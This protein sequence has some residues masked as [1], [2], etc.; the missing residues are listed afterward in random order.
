MKDNRQFIIYH[1]PSTGD[2]LPSAVRT[3]CV[4][5]VFLAFLFWLPTSI[6]ILVPC[7]SGHI[8]AMGAHGLAFEAESS[9]L[10]SLCTTAGVERLKQNKTKQ[11]NNH[12]YDS[13]LVPRHKLCTFCDLTKVSFLKSVSAGNLLNTYHKST[14]EDNI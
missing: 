13:V 14:C 4:I 9:R 3:K 1:L 11:K 10:E 2:T 8:M 6:S 5:L 12:F 7:T